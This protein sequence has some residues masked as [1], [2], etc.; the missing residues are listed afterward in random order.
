M[1]VHHRFVPP[2]PPWGAAAGF[3][4]GHPNI[5]CSPWV[6]NPQPRLPNPQHYI[7]PPPSHDQERSAEES[8][9][10]SSES[11]EGDSLE[12]NHGLP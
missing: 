8:P 12:A 3:D 2:G 1:Q 9:S 5:A 6:N 11:G 10:E 7:P 4:Q